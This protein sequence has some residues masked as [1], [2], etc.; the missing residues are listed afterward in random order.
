MSGPDDKVDLPWERVNLV[1]QR[2]M[3]LVADLGRINLH[4]G[5]ALDEIVTSLTMQDAEA[6]I[7]YVEYLDEADQALISGPIG[8]KRRGSVLDDSLASVLDRYCANADTRTGEVV[9]LV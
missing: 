8:I 4:N 6:Y 2:G 9:P 7:K 3:E 5:D 1:H